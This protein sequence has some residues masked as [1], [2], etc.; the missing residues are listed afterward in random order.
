MGF[1]LGSW[2]K[3][4]VCVAIL[5][6]KDGEIVAIDMLIKIYF[7][8]WYD[9]ADSKTRECLFGKLIDPQLCQTMATENQLLLLV[10]YRF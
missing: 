6:M 9:W 8:V 5:S 2:L 7:H 1:R 3:W 10:K 4:C